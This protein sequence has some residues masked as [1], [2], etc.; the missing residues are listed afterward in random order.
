VEETVEEE[1]ELK[2]RLRNGA[3]VGLSGSTGYV[4]GDVTQSL[5]DGRGTGCFSR[6]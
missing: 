6:R 3:T 1:W 4:K 5:D 2:S